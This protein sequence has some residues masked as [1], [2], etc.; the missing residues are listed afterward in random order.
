MVGGLTVSGQRNSHYR[1]ARGTLW[2]MNRPL[3]LEGRK[4]SGGVA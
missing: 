3:S 2:D 4:V 1:A